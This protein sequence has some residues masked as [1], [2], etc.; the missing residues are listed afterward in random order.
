MK[1]RRTL[2]ISLL[3]V[4]ALTLGIGYA[5]VSDLLDITGIVEADGSAMNTEFDEDV[6]FSAIQ[7]NDTK[8]GE[9]ALGTGDKPDNATFMVAGLADINETASVTY[10]ITND[11]ADSV[12]VTI[13]EPSNDK[14]DYLEITHD[15]TEGTEI[16]AGQS[17]TVTVTATVVDTTSESTSLNYGLH[18]H[19]ENVN[20]NP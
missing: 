4:A 6:Y 15:L 7:I 8:A 13:I 2:I 20:P 19:V 16:A 9:S 17:I 3:L 11:Y 18:L 5:S 10:T 14:N 1:K 12:W